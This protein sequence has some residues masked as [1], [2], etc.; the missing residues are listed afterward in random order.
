MWYHRI[1]IEKKLIKTAVLL[2]LG[3]VKFL[4][5]MVYREELYSNGLYDS[6]LSNSTV[7]LTPAGHCLKQIIES[8]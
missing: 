1:L 7:Q 2:E 3:S 4:I 6:C 8:L 5:S